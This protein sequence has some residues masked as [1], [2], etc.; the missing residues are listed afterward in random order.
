MW[1]D[2]IKYREKYLKYLLIFIIFFSACKKENP[3]LPINFKYNYFPLKQSLQRIYKIIDIT[4]DTAINKYDTI[5]YELKEIIDSSF[6][7]NSGNIAWRLERYKRSDS[8]QQWQISDVWENQI[9]NN[10]AHSIEENIRYI[11][12]IFPPKKDDTWNGNAFNTLDAKNYTLS[13][14]DETLALNEQAFDSVLTV[15]QENNTTLIS[16]YQTIEQ[17]A[18]N[19]GLINKTVIAIDYAY[20]YPPNVPIEQRISRGHLYYQT[21]ISHN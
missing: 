14:I 12:I 7:D 16:K 20:T 21:I 8:T 15:Y 5:N 17:Y 18:T 11:K 10:Q 6:I 2:L 4:I 13:N 19:I 3:S 1:Q 9:V